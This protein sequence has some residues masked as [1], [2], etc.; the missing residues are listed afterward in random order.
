MRNGKVLSIR[1][2][3]L[4]AAISFLAFSPVVSVAE[5][6]IWETHLKAAVHYQEA[7]NY[8]AAE[9]ACLAAV[10]ETEKF[11][12]GDLRLATSLNNLALLYKI[13]AKYAEAESI[14]QRALGIVEKALGPEH[15]HLASI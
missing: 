4:Q 5:D 11:G 9:N 8:A 6:S 1:A 10:K 15:L 12:S 3:G 7:G 2:L 14:Y 13:Q